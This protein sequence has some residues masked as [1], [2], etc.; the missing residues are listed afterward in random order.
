MK[1]GGCSSLY[2]RWF[3]L[4]KSE[5]L[6][7]LNQQ[8]LVLQLKGDYKG[9]AELGCKAL[10]TA[11]SEFGLDHPDVAVNLTNLGLLYAEVEPLYK[12][13]VAIQGV[14]TLLTSWTNSGLE[15]LRL[16]RSRCPLGARPRRLPSRNPPL[17]FA[18]FS[19]A[20]RAGGPGG[21]RF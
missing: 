13:A 2:L 6:V 5:E 21:R 10:E 15:S 1:I 12:R 8:A 11:E 19:L 17:A 16:Q 18:L 9:A 3:V 7:R 20:R 14:G 4:P